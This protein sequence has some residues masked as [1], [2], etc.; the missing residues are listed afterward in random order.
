MENAIRPFIVGRKNWLFSNTASGS[1]TSAFLCSLISIAQENGINAE[2]YLTELFSQPVG[3]IILP[4]KENE[5]VPS[6]TPLSFRNMTI[7]F[8]DDERQYLMIKVNQ[9]GYPRSG[10]KTARISYFEKFG[11]L[12]GKTYEI[13]NADTDEVSTPGTYYIRISNVELDASARSSRDVAEGLDTDTVT[14]VMF[15]IQDDVYDDFLSDLI[16][17][18]YY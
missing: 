18:T 7:S 4:W 16:K 3:I 9:V 17:Y 1:E 10:V 11:S 14:S 8:T 12:V 13:V 5:H 6:G 2:K 15:R